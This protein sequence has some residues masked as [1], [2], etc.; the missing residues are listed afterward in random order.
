MSS[1]MQPSSAAGL[2]GKARESLAK[3]L[4]WVLEEEGVLLAATRDFRWQ[5]TGPNLYSLHRLFDE[6]RRQLGYW[7]ERV[8]EQTKLVGLRG[9]PDV[10]TAPAVRPGMGP[11]HP[12]S[13][14]SMLGELLGRHEAMARR[15]R[16]DIT[17][18]PDPATADLLNHLMEFH[19]T[20]AWMLRMVV[21]QNTGPDLVP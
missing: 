6:Q 17:R 5:V 4:E 15:L 18:L 1:G 19:E 16:E 9:K 7:V 13:A 21:T 10:E 8:M 12:L 2:T 20:T 14:P 3:V 11:Q